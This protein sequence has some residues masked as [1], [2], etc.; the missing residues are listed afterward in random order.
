MAG[1]HMN[2]DNKFS[3]NSKS[4]VALIIATFLCLISSQLSA[5][6]SLNPQQVELHNISK[7]A[8][9]EYNEGKND[10]QKSEVYN[11]VN[12]QKSEFG[13][14]INWHISEWKGNVMKISTNQGGDYADVEI[15]SEHN[16]IE[17]SFEDLSILGFGGVQ[18]SDAVYEQ[19]KELSEG[20]PVIFS[21]ELNKGER[22][23][24]EL[25]LTEQGSICSPEFGI[26][27]TSIKLNP[28]GEIK[29]SNAEEF[30]EGVKEG[31]K[32]F[33]WIID[34]IGLIITVIIVFL[35]LN[36]FTKKKDQK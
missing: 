34:N 9:T 2:S 30:A 17:I 3:I 24:E 31:L 29:K 12:E 18:K 35:I 7:R 13:G 5:Q 22:G 21:G 26:N 33:I 14:K 15:V 28:N 6:V 4:F 20:D 36:A 11:Q 16:S 27:L 23:I 8:C 25:S 10:I 19:L 1:M 32:P